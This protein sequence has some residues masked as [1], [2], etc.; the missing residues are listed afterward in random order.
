MKKQA[1][2]WLILSFLLLAS[3]ASSNSELV[4]VGYAG[5]S[6]VRTG[7]SLIMTVHTVSPSAKD[8]VGVPLFMGSSPLDRIRFNEADQRTLSDSL[9]DE[10]VRIG[11]FSGTTPSADATR[12]DLAF[13][14][15]D[16][17]SQHFFEY[18]LAFSITISTPGRS[19]FRKDYELSSLEGLTT[20]QKWNQIAPQSKK[21]A[22]EL[23]LSKVIPDIEAY[24]AG[25]P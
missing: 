9:G 12:I 22:A 11:M 18:K 5:S 20:R 1:K 16:F 21:H 25:G 10:L 4:R 24:F 6:G 2:N 7:K 8:V 19:D 17:L 13:K 15:T 3:C 23:A 14:S